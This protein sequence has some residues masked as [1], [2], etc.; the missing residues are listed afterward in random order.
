[1]KKHLKSIIVLL[2]FMSGTVLQAQYNPMNASLTGMGGAGVALDDFNAGINNQAAWSSVETPSVSLGYNS[3]FLLKELSDRFLSLAVPVG[4][5]SGVFGMN[6]SQ[7]GYSQYNITKAGLGYARTFGPDFSVGLQFDAIHAGTADEMYGSTNAFTF[8]GG[9]QYRLNKQ[10]S[11]GSSIFNPVQVKLSDFTGE[12]LPA[13]ISLGMTYSPD[14][15]LML[16]ADIVKEQY[17][18]ASFRAGFRYQIVD[19][20]CLRGGF[21]SAPFI[22]SGGAGI[23]FGNFTADLS[24]S[25]H[26]ILGISPGLSLVYKFN[27]K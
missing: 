16:A 12:Q 13:S 2:L 11:L 1:M 26:Q 7:F 15:L 20:F 19:A 23:N 17:Q 25:Y 18:P 5:S 4:K 21:S 24:T 3:R 8:E 10:I 27:K 14:K 22:L 9:F 6:V